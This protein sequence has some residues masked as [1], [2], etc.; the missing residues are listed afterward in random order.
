MELFTKTSGT[1][2]LSL[3]LNTLEDKDIELSA[4]EES[5][6]GVLTYQISLDARKVR[7]KLVTT[8]I[9]EIKRIDVLSYD[10]SGVTLVRRYASR[11]I[12][13]SISLDKLCK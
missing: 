4:T 3:F 1:Y 11:Q 7:H 13:P 6:A 8:L 5:E 2:V 12:E 9:N 10:I